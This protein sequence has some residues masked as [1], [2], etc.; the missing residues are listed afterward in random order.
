MG[1][2][3]DLLARIQVLENENQQLK[4]ENKALKDKEIPKKLLKEISFDGGFVHKNNR[5]PKCKS[6][7]YTESLCCATCGQRLDWGEEDE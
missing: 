3:I 5:C 7:H 1:E 2:R 4:Q 6:I